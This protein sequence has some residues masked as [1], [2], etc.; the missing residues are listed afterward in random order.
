[1]RQCRCA[2]CPPPFGGRS[3]YYPIVMAIIARRRSAGGPCSLCSELVGLACLPCSRHRS[4]PT[5][6]GQ[7][8][9]LSY[10]RSLDQVR[11]RTRN[12]RS[13]SP[14]LRP[15]FLMNRPTINPWRETLSRQQEPRSGIRP[16]PA[17]RRTVTHTRQGSPLAKFS[18]TDATAGI[19][20]D[21]IFS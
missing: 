13:R 5:M 8:K 19:P 9:S 20:G 10:T 12:L 15:V 14:L 7:P 17:H 1:M 18:V 2:P 6:L 4:N 21:A 11:W 3:L 16:G